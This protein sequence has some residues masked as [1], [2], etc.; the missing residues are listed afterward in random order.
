MKKLLYKATLILLPLAAASVVALFF[1]LDRDAWKSS[2]RLAT[3]LKDAREVV[4]VEYSGDVEI[5]RKSAT[6][7][8][9]SQLY[10]AASAWP[11]PFVPSG[12]LCFEP[13]HRLEVVRADGS[14]WIAAICFLCDKFAI[15]EEPYLSPLPPSLA[16]SLASYFISIGMTPKS[17]SQ[18]AM[19][20]GA[21]QT[22]SEGPK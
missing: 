7:N 2:A 5:A 10:N 3:A 15:D 1:Y 11:R 18:Y 14:R 19:I 12:Y 13:H 9:I 17:E 20:A 21:G 16:N 22:K 4:L 6:P 8:E